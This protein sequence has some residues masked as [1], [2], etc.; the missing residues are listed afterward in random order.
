MT[1]YPIPEI[2]R[3]PLESISLSVKVTRENEDVKRFLGRAIDPPDVSSLD[4]AWKTLKELGA[5]DVND[6]LTGLGKHMAMLPVDLRIG[7]VTNLR[8]SSKQVG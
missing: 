1:K 5:I 2:L 6:C 4:R 7:K 8:I 3:V